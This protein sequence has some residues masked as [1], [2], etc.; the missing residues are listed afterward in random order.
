[1]STDTTRVQIR[2]SKQ[3]K[4][5]AT[6]TLGRM[7]LDM[8]GAINMYLQQIVNLQELPFTP[9]AMDINTQ[10]RWEAEHHVGATFSTVGELMK[11][12]N[13]DD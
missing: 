8:T 13:G 3:L 2:T 5:Q 11:D 10:A 6:E 9:T 4:Q 7:G 1:M 12:L